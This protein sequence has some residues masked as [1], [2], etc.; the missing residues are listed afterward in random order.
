MLTDEPD[1]DR[2]IVILGGGVAGL[3]ASYYTGAPVYESEVRCGGAAASDSCDGF[4]FDRGIHVL[5]T[6]DRQI[7]QLLEELGIEFDII[8]RSA[9]IYAFG[10]YTSYPFQ[11]NSTNLRIDRR[12]RC[13][14]SFLR[15]GANPEPTNYAGW[16]YRSI[17][18]GFGDTFLI[19]YSEKFWGVHPREMS[20]EWTG[21]RV[22]KADIWQVLRGAVIS[23]N[24]RAGTNATFRYP[25][26]HQGYGA[27]PEALRRAIGNRLHTNHRAMKVDTERKQLVFKDQGVKDYHVLLNTIPV[28]DLISIASNVPESVT[29]A[30]ASL[31]TNSIMVVNLGIARAD[32]TDKHWIHFPEKNISFFRISFPHNFSRGLVPAG[33]SSISAE[34]SYPSSAPP[35]R[36]ALVQR[37]V[38]DLIKV[39]I[40]GSD[41]RVVA[42][43]TRDIP[44]G[45]CIYDEQRRQALPVIRRWLSQ[46][47]I[48]P[49]GRYGLWTYFWSDEAMVSGRK[50]GAIATARAAGLPEPEMETSELEA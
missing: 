4:A 10:K 1:N 50:A 42:R 37:V 36:D 38:E 35:D 40:L 9:H 28:P 7:V 25:K 17:G 45:Y 11:I 32:L 43:H 15:R 48:V 26:G 29:R 24:T 44:Y 13:V 49:G 33:M 3:T 12:I 14:W 34:V 16:I 46:V 2:G 8:D 18:R 22:P 27:V 47:D 20:F 21:N 6:T 31:R 23:R 39:G 41:D 19:P 5:Q 30:V